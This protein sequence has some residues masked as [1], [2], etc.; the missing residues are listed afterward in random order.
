M[1][2]ERQLYIKDGIISDCAVIELNG[3]QISNPTV[4]M[5]HEAG[6]VEYT[7]EPHVRTLEE[8]KQEEINEINA[9][10]HTQGYP[11]KLHFNV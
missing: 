1:A 6:W 11:E 3:R 10:D 5:I 4:E 8:A 7:P 2:N 9:C